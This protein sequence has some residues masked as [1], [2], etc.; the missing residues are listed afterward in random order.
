MQVKRRRTALFFIFTSLL[1]TVCRCSANTFGNNAIPSLYG[2]KTV[3]MTCE[4]FT[5]YGEIA[6]GPSGDMPWSTRMVFE[7]EVACPDG[8]VAKFDLFQ[9]PELFMQASTEEEKSA[10]KAQY[11]SAEAMIPAGLQSAPIEA[12]TETPT[13]SPE[14]S[15]EAS[16]IIQPPNLLIIAPYL[17]GTVTACDTA[18]GYVN[19]PLFTPTPDTVGKTLIVTIN[20]VPV[21]CTVAGTNSSI[22]S[23][24]L[25]QD[26][27]YPANVRV[28][29]DGVE[30]NNFNF[31][32]SICTHIVPPAATDEDK[33][34]N[35]PPAT[36]PPAT[37]PPATEPPN[38]NSSSSP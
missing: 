38:D 34:E 14:P 12:T 31:N 29:L 37:E 10:F 13:A 9:R 21:N 7:C 20:S 35:Q 4:Q 17:G 5:E 36:E 30:I 27:A 22:L 32:D 11:C 6:G 26:T 28:T 18:Q 23:C 8:S 24:A 1:V 33:E 2:D 16:I 19:F 3:A 15:Q 25:P